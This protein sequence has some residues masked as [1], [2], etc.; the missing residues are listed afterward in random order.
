MINSTY[1]PLYILF[2]T[3]V[4][5]ACSS[6]EQ[7]KIEEFFHTNIRD[8]NS[9]EF[10]FSLLVSTKQKEARKEGNSSPDSNNR[11]GRKGKGQRGQNTALAPTA[12]KQSSKQ[13]KMKDIFHERL[14]LQMERAQY[15]REGYI[16]LEESFV[17]AIYTLRGECH[18][19]ASKG[20]RKR[21]L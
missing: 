6:K 10:T 17:G 12:K 1:S 11:K 19:S 2:F 8:D 13:D 4:L 7:P 21:F 20:D 16:T 9:K 15:C 18:E 5:S 14:I 3:M